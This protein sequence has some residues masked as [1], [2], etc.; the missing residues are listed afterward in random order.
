MSTDNNLLSFLQ[1]QSLFSNSPGKPGRRNSSRS[2]ERMQMQQMQN[3]LNHNQGGNIS[4]SPPRGPAIQDN[5]L[6]YQN[7]FANQNNFQN[8]P[9]Q[10]QGQFQGGIV[11]NGVNHQG[12]LG[13]YGVYDQ[14]IRIE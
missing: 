1:K 11:Q 7:Q 14:N 4:L 10:F 9:G 2:R 12:N 6:A 5:R 13:G 3:N 8:T